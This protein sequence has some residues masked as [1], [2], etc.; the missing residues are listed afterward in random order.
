MRKNHFMNELYFVCVQLLSLCG[1]LFGT[2]THVEPCPP[3]YWHTVGLLW[4]SDQPV[5]E[6]STYTEQHNTRDKT[7][8]TSAGF[9]AAMPATKRP[10]TYALDSA[11]TGIGLNYFSIANDPDD[12]L[13][14]PSN[15]MEQSR[16][17]E[18]DKQ[19]VNEFPPPPIEHHC[20]SRCQ[21]S[22]L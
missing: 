18:I 4:T 12:L 10:Q 9:E 5:T 14:Q 17:W 20:S 22:H 7:S 8:M 16:S 2:T 13:K 21:I 6:A 11:A 1:F 15:S 3:L 19:F